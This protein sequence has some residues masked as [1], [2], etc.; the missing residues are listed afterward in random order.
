MFSEIRA[1]NEIMYRNMVQQ[2]RPQTTEKRCNMHAGQLRL[3]KHIQN[4]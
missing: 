2:E 1:V 3:Q 4:M